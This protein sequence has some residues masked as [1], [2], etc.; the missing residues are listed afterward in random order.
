MGDTIEIWSNTKA[1][2]SSMS[3]EEFGDALEELLGTTF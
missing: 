2:E 3:A 1:E